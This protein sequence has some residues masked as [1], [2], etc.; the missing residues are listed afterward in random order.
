MTKGGSACTSCERRGNR[1]G[2]RRQSSSQAVSGHHPL[3]VVSV[4]V[5]CTMLAAD[6]AV[7][8][9]VGDIRAAPACSSLAPVRVRAH[10]QAHCWS[11]RPSSAGPAPAAAPQPARWQTHSL[12]ASPPLLS[13]ALL[14]APRLA[15]A[16]RT[17]T[18]GMRSTTGRHR[19]VA[20]H[21][22][23]HSQVPPAT[24]TSTWRAWPSPSCTCAPPA[25]R[26]RLRAAGLCATVLWW[27]CRSLACLHRP[28]CGHL[29]TSCSAGSEVWLRCMRCS[30]SAL[31]W[32]TTPLRV[33][34]V[35]PGCRP[36]SYRG[37]VYLAVS[38]AGPVG[39]RGWAAWAGV[40]AVLLAVSMLGTHYIQQRAPL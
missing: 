2:Q 10:G 33:F 38:R 21:R 26:P 1:R 30:S 4:V 37:R 31:R 8:G 39:A 6:S 7:R 12:C 5:A 35:T 9:T 29:R 11:C 23:H 36:S 24:S 40:L 13:A 25:P 14:V 15:S 16:S 34:S 19:A 17:R 28:C 27:L 20:G 3:Y 32:A 18:I 22:R